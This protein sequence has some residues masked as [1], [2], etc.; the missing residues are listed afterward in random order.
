M[1]EQIETLVKLQKIETETWQV[2]TILNNV[3][4]KI[5]ALDTR[6]SSCELTVAETAASLE[7][8]KK[9]YRE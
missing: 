4:Q 3:S 1:K 9:K 7:E 8:L 2:N 6:L 5:N